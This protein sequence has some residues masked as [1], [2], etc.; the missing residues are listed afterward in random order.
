MG[1]RFIIF[2]LIL[3]LL[4]VL[5]NIH[6]SYR[7][8]KSFKQ[9]FENKIKIRLF[10]IILITAQL[11][12]NS[13]I[14][15]IWFV[16]DIE[17]I[18]KHYLYIGFYPWYILSFV[19]IVIG[20]IG[21]KYSIIRISIK[22]FKYIIYVFKNRTFR[23]KKDKID[24]INNQR[25]LFLNKALLTIIPTF[26]GLSAYKVYAGEFDYTINRFNLSFDNLP[27]GLKDLRIVQISDIH[28]GMFM[29]ERRLSYYT[30]IVNELNP[31]I[32]VIT[33]DI[34]DRNVRMIKTAQKELSKLKAKYGVYGIL[35][36]HDFMAGADEV[37]RGLNAI[38]IDI[39]RN[40]YRTIKINNE[41]LCLIGIDYTIMDGYNWH[42]HRYSDRIAK[43]LL[44]RI[45]F[46]EIETDFRIF[47]I[48]HPHAFRVVNDNSKDDKY[49][50]SL[51]LAGHTHGGGQVNL[52]PLEETHV[53]LGH[54]AYQY[55]NGLYKEGNK[56]LYVNHGLGYTAMPIRINCP[57]EITEF[58]LKSE[59]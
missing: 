44:D 14:L 15:L 23:R 12:I 42:P 59:N 54:V 18:E 32:I 51:A 49:K 53:G 21:I 36:N 11:L 29:R 37:D 33:G 43:K 52:N 5:A 16:N 25:R 27:I 47:L 22:I 48:H 41:N 39:I 6:F 38:N 2:F 8:I 26:I 19:V 31:D 17:T 13:P 55:I 24:S 3:T 28:I 9:V 58:T 46:D 30:Q 34:I 10:K 45:N 7:L 40:E 20:F 4:L 35:G 57:P 1:Y 50:I 56:Y